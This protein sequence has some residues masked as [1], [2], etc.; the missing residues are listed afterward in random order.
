MVPGLRH[1]LAKFKKR[2]KSVEATAAAK[3]W[4]CTKPQI[5]ALEKRQQEREACGEIETH[6]PGCLGSRDTY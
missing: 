1:N 6:H 2:Q 5:A 4:V 3:G